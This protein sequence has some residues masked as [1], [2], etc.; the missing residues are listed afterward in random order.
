VAYTLIALIILRVVLAGNRSA[1][2]EVPD[3]V[4]VRRTDRKRAL[5]YVLGFSLATGVLVLFA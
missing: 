5:W 3:W 2:S 4:A 1:E